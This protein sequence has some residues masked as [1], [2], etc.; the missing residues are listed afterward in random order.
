[1]VGW[2]SRLTRS[3]RRGVRPR[4]LLVALRRSADLAPRSPRRLPWPL[5]DPIVAGDVA[6]T[7]LKTADNSGAAKDSSSGV[8][9]P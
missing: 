5:S 1:M 9:E 7:K 2:L 6:V 3:L 8:G 4:L